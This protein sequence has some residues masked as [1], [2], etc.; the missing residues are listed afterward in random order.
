M[1]D[2][3]WFNAYYY[4][5]DNRSPTDVHMY[6]V[7]LV[8]VV[9]LILINSLLGSS[10]GRC[11]DDPPCATMRVACAYQGLFVENIISNI[12][13]AIITTKT[14]VGGQITKLN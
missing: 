2:N 11:C 4:R 3:I 10:T 8:H 14:F 1:T 9:D 13:A 12:I 6:G 7:G 5:L